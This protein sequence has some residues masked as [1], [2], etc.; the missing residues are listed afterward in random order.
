MKVADSRH[1][2]RNKWDCCRVKLI[3]FSIE[4]Y[5]RF[6]E[7]SSL[8]VSG[9]MVALV[10]P[11]E[12][13]KS[14]ALR[15]LARLGD[16]TEFQP[17]E[18]PRRTSGKPRLSWQF[19]LEDEDRSVISEIPGAAQL[20]RVSLERRAG[21]EN[22][23]WTFEPPVRRDR[24]VRA[25]AL[26]SLRSLAKAIA[27]R[28]RQDHEWPDL[29]PA[30]NVL[31]IDRD[32][33]GRDAL[34]V[35]SGLV[36]ALDGHL[37]SDRSPHETNQDRAV[38]G[39]AS[40]MRDALEA[41]V[42]NESRP[43]PAALLREALL[44]RVPKIFL[45][46]AEDRNLASE[47]DLAQVA[48]NTPPALNH[49][50]VLAGLDLQA[51][52]KEI[53]E[54]R[55][56]DAS[57]RRNA[58]NRR[59][60][61]AFDQAWNQQGIAVQL[62]FQGTL[63]LVQATTPHDSGLSPISERSDGF[64]WFAALMSY[65]HGWKQQP[66]LLVDEIE[67]HLHY[68][69]QADLIDVL[70]QQQFTSKIIYTT[71]SFG[72]LPSDL[73]TGV[74]VVRPV[75]AATSVFQNGYWRQGSGFS[76]MLAS[77]GAAASTFTP[78]RHAVL[79]EGPS[80]AIL[81]PT[82]LRQAT[83]ARSLRYQVAPGLASVAAAEV[84]TLDAEA[85]RV[86]FLVDGDS[87]GDAITRKLVSGGVEEGRI[88]ALEDPITGER[89]EFEDLIDPREYASA[90]NAE[91]RLWQSPLDELQVE[92]LAANF[93]S[94]SVESWATARGLSCPEKCAVAQRLA[95]AALETSVVHPQRVELLKALH[96]DV[97]RILRL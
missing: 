93:A 59:L 3:S 43:S 40:K 94:K 64:R 30:I 79:A 76:P 36:N 12:A 63:L 17:D 52:L 82:L 48:G 11:N 2:A 73:G 66:I 84:P 38:R 31:G 49:L 70:S 72:C 1:G 7:R 45:F 83:G 80:E 96:G 78:T 97:E 41:L 58:A 47:Y 85:G 55:I 18:L 19:E 28:P 37:G 22:P 29:E 44:P 87:A 34:Q 32:D 35:L 77:M 60:Y 69:A 92:D 8:K 86:A 50:A 25:S 81:L 91:L 88:V 24:S 27:K 65:A 14:S 51:L 10:G 26:A 21:S 33:L 61:E 46:G 42:E 68:D 23:L 13:G 53:Q 9:P 39:M 57:T 71:H 74:R 16:R 15:A 95:D 5:R 67:T 4:N 56:A 89:L 20:R 54:G 90:V 6:V 62:E 75:D